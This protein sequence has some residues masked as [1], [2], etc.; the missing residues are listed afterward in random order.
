MDKLL[1]A[2]VGAYIMELRVKYIGRALAIGYVVGFV[3]GVVCAYY[4]F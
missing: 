4:A 1:E 2:R 3:V